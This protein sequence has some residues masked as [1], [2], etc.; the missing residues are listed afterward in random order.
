MNNSSNLNDF[1]ENYDE[2]HT[3]KIVAVMLPICVSLIFVTYHVLRCSYNQQR[4][5]NLTQNTDAF[6]S[7]IAVYE[8]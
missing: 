8:V 3:N 4:K 7:P 6:T 1:H 5:D 2:I